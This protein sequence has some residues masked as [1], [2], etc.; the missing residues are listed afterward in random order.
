MDDN[1]RTAVT[2]RAGRIGKAFLMYA[3]DNND[4]LPAK[5]T[6]L[7]DLLGP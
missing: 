2:R 1:K 5:G 4:E 7:Q 3:A 6:D